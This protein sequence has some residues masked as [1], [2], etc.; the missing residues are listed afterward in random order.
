[1]SICAVSCPRGWKEP[2]TLRASDLSKVTV[3]IDVVP[4]VPLDPMADRSGRHSPADDEELKLPC[5]VRAASGSPWPVGKKG[6]TLVL[7]LERTEFFQ[8]LPKLGR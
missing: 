2:V 4:M 3:V 6:G 8:Q 7:Q 5:C 1:M